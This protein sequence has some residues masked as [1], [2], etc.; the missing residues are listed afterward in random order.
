MGI[1]TWVVFGL[2]AGGI[3]KLIMPGK[4][5]GGCFITT[6]LGVVGASVGGWIGTMFG[7][8]TVTEFNLKSMALAV[9]GAI[10]LL[11]IYRVIFGKKD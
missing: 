1:L 3:A 2:I 10:I 7:W 6:I 4:D 8:G 9:G 5:P 11:I